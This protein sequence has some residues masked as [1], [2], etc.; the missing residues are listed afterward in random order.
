MKARATT[1]PPQSQARLAEA[2]ERLVMLYDAWGKPDEAATW[3]KEFE[4]LRP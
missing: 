2:V 4:A 1:I 3:K